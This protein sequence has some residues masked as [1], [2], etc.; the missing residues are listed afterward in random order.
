MGT[1]RGKLIKTDPP[2]QPVLPASGRRNPSH[3][4]DIYSVPDQLES[5][6]DRQFEQFI[7]QQSIQ[8]QLRGVVHEL[9]DKC[10]E[11]CMKDSKPGPKL[12][13]KTQDCMRSCVDRFM[14]ANI[15]VSRRMNEEGDALAKAAA[16]NSEELFS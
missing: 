3:C 10:W 15:M 11:V 6:M 12:E 13:Y 14:D 1:T 4:T 16:Q 2:C 7:Q 9:T 8:Q 5:I